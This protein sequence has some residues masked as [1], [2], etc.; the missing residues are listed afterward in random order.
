MGFLLKPHDFSFHSSDIATRHQVLSN[1]LIFITFFAVAFTLP[2][3][4]VVTAT[5]DQTEQ[6]DAEFLPS[7]STTC[8][9][10]T[11]DD[12]PPDPVS[13][14]LLF[15]SFDF[16]S[17]PKLIINFSVFPSSSMMLQMLQSLPQGN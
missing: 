17:N 10:K 9:T 6:Q 14:F 8:E 7:S 1:R 2:F 16:N 5:V 11:L 13:C 12:V 4:G 15:S 3:Y